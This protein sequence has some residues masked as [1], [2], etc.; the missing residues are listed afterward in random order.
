MHPG[1]NGTQ[2]FTKIQ[3]KLKK[4]LFQKGMF[5]GV[6]GIGKF[7]AV[8]ETVGYGRDA[9]KHCSM[10]AVQLRSDRGRGQRGV[11]LAEIHDHLARVSN[12]TEAALGEYGVRI[13]VIVLCSVLYDHIEI[14]HLLLG[15]LHRVADH[16][17]GKFKRDR[18][19]ETD[20][21]C[22]ETHYYTL[23]FPY[24]CDGA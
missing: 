8:A 24:R 17:L 19:I 4:C 21:T 15:S 23:K 14:D 10:L 7:A 20:G 16:L 3:K 2:F 6:N 11:F 5:D 13:E 9:M 22:V 1:H 12:V 18:N